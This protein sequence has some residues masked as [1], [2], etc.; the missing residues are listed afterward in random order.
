MWGGPGLNPAFSS[1][2]VAIHHPCGVDEGVCD[3]SERQPPDL[4]RPRTRDWVVSC[5][6]HQGGPV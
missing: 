4:A 3:P 2:P 5:V 6:E 1:L